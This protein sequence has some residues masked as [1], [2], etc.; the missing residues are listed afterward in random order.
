MEP[1]DYH[2][3]AV[4]SRFADLVWAHAPVSTRE[5]VTLCAEELDWKRT[6]T[7]TVLRRLCQ[8]EDGTVTAQISREAF[9]AAQS[10]QFVTERFGGSLPAFVA[11]FTAG[12]KLK[13]EEVAQLRAMIDAME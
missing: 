6:T 3:G 13:P 7:Y 4:E 9:Y 10:E 8:M 12:K 5:L 2:L 1:K 11:A